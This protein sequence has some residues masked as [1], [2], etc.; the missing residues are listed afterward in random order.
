[1]A[2]LLMAINEVH[3]VGLANAS[4]ILL[5][6][7]FYWDLNEETR[8]FAK[9]FFEKR[10]IMPSLYQAGVY[11]AVAH[12]LKAMKSAGTDKPETAM[13]EMRKLPINDFMTKNGTLRED[14][15]VIREMHVFEVKKPEESKA[16]WD[17]YKHVRTVPGEA[18]FR[19]LSD[20]ACPL[21]K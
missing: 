1:M 20:K 6:S 11:S 5:T 10:K 16:A 4:G 2:T 3:S 19:P 8:A 13:A 15:R 14:G 18:A 17:Y 9:R 12:Y 21:L 7:P